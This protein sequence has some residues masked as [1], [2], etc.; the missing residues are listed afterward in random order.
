MSNP[1]K[2]ALAYVRESKEE[3]EKVSWPSRQKTLRYSLAVVGV[4]LLMGAFFAG[5][6]WALNL[7]L[8][9]LIGL[10]S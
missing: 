2:L 5:V 1:L 4:A 3:L 9:K 7:G 10:T 8:E 6:D